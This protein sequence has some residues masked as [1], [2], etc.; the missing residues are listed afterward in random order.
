MKLLE[1]QGKQLF[2]RV[3]L[4][5]PPGRLAYTPDEAERST[6]ELGGPVVVKA[7]VA[8]GGRGKAGGVK[9]AQT[10][11]EA[12]RQAEAILGLTIQGEPVRTLLITRAVEIEREYYLGITLDRSARKPVLIFSMQ[13]G[14]DIE[15]VARTSPESIHTFHIS[16]LEGLQA[17][18]VRGLLFESDVPRDQ[19][20]ALGDVIQKLYRAFAEFRAHLVEI[21]P[22]AVAAQGEIWALDSKFILDDDDLPAEIPGGGAET[23]DPLERAAKEADLQYVKLDGDIGII[24]NGAGLVMSTLDVVQLMGGRPANF[25]DVGGGASAEQ[26]KKALELVLSDPDVKGVFINIFGGITRCDLVAQGI[27]AAKRDLDIHAPM[28]GRLVGTNEEEGRRILHEAAGV[29]PVAGMEEG[30]EKIVRLV[31]ESGQPSA[32]C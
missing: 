29:I 17:H 20:R 28:V 5:V 6:R 27:V 2:E 12:R 16:P 4:P 32:E 24:G 26:M 15:E 8:A 22:I 11:E 9:L 25:L 10:P 21:N 18:Q 7:Q 1:Y 23:L 13:G 30:A 19:F 3:G 31:H 14:V